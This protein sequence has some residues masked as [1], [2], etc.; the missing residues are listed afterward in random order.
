MIDLEKSTGKQ[1]VNYLIEKVFPKIQQDFFDYIKIHKNEFYH[2]TFAL[3][4]NQ[5]GTI[6]RSQGKLNIHSTSFNI[7]NIFTIFD[8]LKHYTKKLKISIKQ[9]QG[10]KVKY[11]YVATLHPIESLRDALA[12]FSPDPN[13]KC[14]IEIYMRI[15]NKR[16]RFDIT[17]N[18]I[19]YKWL[20]K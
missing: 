20:K 13:Y 10:E 15:K 11:M 4:F 7:F 5:K 6:M 9:V 3:I 17:Q 1:I 16:Y 12:I 14:K 2:R 19:K 8:V 18:N